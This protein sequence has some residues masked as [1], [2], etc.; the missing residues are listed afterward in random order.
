MSSMVGSFG[1]VML[2][3]ISVS[4]RSVWQGYISQAC[5]LAFLPISL[6]SI[7]IGVPAAAFDMR[8]FQESMMRLM[9]GRPE[10]HYNVID[11][12]T[13]S[14]TETIFQLTMHQANSTD[15]AVS[16]PGRAKKEEEDTCSRQQFMRSSHKLEAGDVA[17]YQRAVYHPW[18]TRT[19]S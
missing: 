1:N 11:W 2:S 15:S 16:A 6:S 3:V 12:P 7:H 9:L 17:T 18:A 14:T 13:C 19:S 8:K 4:S 10:V 5:L